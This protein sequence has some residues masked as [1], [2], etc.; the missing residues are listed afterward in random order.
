LIGPHRLGRFTARLR[1]AVNRS[2]GPQAHRSGM[3]RW[4]YHRGRGQRPWG[5]GSSSRSCGWHR[6]EGV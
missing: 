6:H 1:R 4:Y 2:G 5:S 3:A